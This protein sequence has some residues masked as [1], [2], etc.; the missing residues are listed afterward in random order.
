MARLT[1]AQRIEIC[2][3]VAHEAMRAYKI[4]LGEDVL[5]VWDKLSDDL[6]ASTIAGVA[7]RLKNPNAPLSAQHDQW[8]AERMAAGWRKGKVKDAKLKTHPSLIPYEKLQET[9]RRKDALIAQV[10]EAICGKL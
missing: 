2:A 3:R 9:E 4:G 6:R 5:P 10:V 1:K 8:M 7:Y